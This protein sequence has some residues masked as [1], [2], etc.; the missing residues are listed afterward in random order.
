MANNYIKPHNNYYTGGKMS[1]NQNSEN[2][3]QRI[4]VD[5]IESINEADKTKLG[6]SYTFWVMMKSNKHA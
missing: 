5:T 1:A 6:R 2:R 3:T 4:K